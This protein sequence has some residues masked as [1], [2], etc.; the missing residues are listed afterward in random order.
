MD[1][2]HDGVYTHAGKVADLK[3][4]SRRRDAA[5]TIATR[6]EFK[7]VGCDHDD[8]GPIG[9]DPDLTSQAEATLIDCKL[10]WFPLLVVFP[11]RGH[12]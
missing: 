4:V 11:M 9:L 1:R 10:L 7:G 2:S 8:A 12:R 3:P 6:D 5:D